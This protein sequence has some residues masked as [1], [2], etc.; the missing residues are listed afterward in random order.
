MR[1][2]PLF[3]LSL[4]NSNKNRR[5][6]SRLSELI[7][8]L[9]PK[10]VEY[11]KL[12]EITINISSGKNKEKLE[13][14]KFF[15]Y[16]ST[17]IIGYTNTPI[18]NYQQILVARVGNAGYVQLVN[19]EYDVSD[20]TLMVNVIK[21]YDIKYMFY[22]LKN[23]NLNK[24]ARG[25]AQP[26][27]TAKQLKELSIPVPPLP[28]QEEIVRILDKYTA[29]ETEL[30]EKLEAELE[31]R[32]QQ[33]EY[34]REKLLKFEGTQF[35]RIGD[36]AKCYAGA[37]PSTSKPEYWENG[38]IP[39]MSSGEVNLGQVYSVEKKITQLGYDK[40]STKM[41][42][43]NTVVIALAGQGK[44][45]G[46]VAITR[47]ELC[48]NQSLC[49]IVND[50]KIINSDFLY[51]FLKSQYL[52]LRKV[53]SGDGTRGGLNLKMIN[54]YKVPIPPLAEQQR[55][56]SILDK[57]EKSTSDLTKEILEEKE[58]R[59]QQYEYYRDKLLTFK[60]KEMVEA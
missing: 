12:E 43:P 44:T 11:K 8:E 47:I 48:T 55:I 39:W 38:T 7:D 37:T 19:G 14:G 46:T 27:I 3:L 21:E 42:P 15:V 41:I 45:R 57:L 22:T 6:M 51:H 32:K 1:W 26:L 29:L 35:K 9:C 56:V 16:G 20:N 18:Y 10:G 60:R 5:T 31:A 34:Y 28:V 49:A 53:S 24:Y 58:A 13:E 36:I 40:S 4:H 30:E 17:G 52:Q 59:R 23:M 33:Y 2:L 50:D 25:A 54:D